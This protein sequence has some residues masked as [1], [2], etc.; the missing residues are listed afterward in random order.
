MVTAQNLALLKNLEIM[1]F[2]LAD[3]MRKEPMYLGGPLPPTFIFK[4]IRGAFKRLI[5]LGAEIGLRE[6]WLMLSN[7]AKTYLL[8]HLAISA[9]LGAAE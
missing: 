2:N 9:T 8:H 3:C 4:N 6:P 1:E 7:I 5:W